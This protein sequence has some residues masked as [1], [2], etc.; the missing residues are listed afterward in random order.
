MELDFGMDG[1]YALTNFFFEFLAFLVVG[2]DRID[3]DK[4][5]GIFFF[6]KLVFYFVR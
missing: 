6:R 4:H 2:G 5:F 3:M 1:A